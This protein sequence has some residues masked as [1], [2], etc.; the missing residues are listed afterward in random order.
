MPQTFEHVLDDKGFHGCRGP[1]EQRRRGDVADGQFQIA[2][3]GL[4]NIKSFRRVA[5]FAIA[6]ALLC[7]CRG[8][9]SNPHDAFASGDFKSPVS[10]VPPPRRSANHHRFAELP[11]QA[12]DDRRGGG[13]MPALL[14]R[15][16][17]WRALRP[18]SR[19]P[20]LFCAAR[21]GIPRLR[22]R[23]RSARDDGQVARRRPI[24]VKLRSPSNH[25][26]GERCSS[27]RIEY[28]FC[29]ASLM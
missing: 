20:D 25:Y 6:D 11:R 1:A 5:F 27:S 26:S 24:V 13:F 7:V 15:H 29:R 3:R 21:A 2:A 14:F 8:R 17:E 12:R 28:I 23:T 18:E 4:I 10:A 9:D 16:P 22:S 19:D